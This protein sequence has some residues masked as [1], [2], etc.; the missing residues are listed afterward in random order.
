MNIKLTNFNKKTK[1]S[2]QVDCF[3]YKAVDKIINTD[4]YDKKN[5]RNKNL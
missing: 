5:H 2:L 4:K 1:N 3:S